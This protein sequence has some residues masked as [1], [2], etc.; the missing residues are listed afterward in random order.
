MP[1]EVIRI[2]E[3]TKL[4]AHE[5]S[6]ELSDHVR[7]ETQSMT[8]DR[9]GEPATLV[10]V[11]AL[12]ALA[13]KGISLWLLKRRSEGQVETIVELTRSD[14]SVERRTIRANFSSSDTPESAVVKEVGSALN[15]SD[16][17]I[18]EALKL[19]R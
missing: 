9:A 4:E 8:T 3:L 2:P 5:L 7:F 19:I 1:Q 16:A 18:K 11:V 14:G 6:E 15:A 12:S 10:A 17:L 13:I